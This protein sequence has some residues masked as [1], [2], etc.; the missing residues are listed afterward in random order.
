VNT[1]GKPLRVVVAERDAD[2]LQTLSDLIASRRH[3][4][5]GGVTDSSM[6]L[7]RVQQLE[8]DVLVVNAQLQ[9]GLAQEVICQILADDLAAVV[10]L[11]PFETHPAAIPLLASGIHGCLAQPVH[12]DNLSLTMAVAAG[13]RAR[14]RALAEQAMRAEERLADHRVIDRAKAVLQEEYGLSEQEAYDWLRRMSMAERSRMRTVADEVLRRHR[15][16]QQ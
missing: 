8:P 1:T 6:A 14:M 11:L 12:L 3:L 10:V 5:V 9:D 15:L 2:S 4:V 16:R 13:L 7:A